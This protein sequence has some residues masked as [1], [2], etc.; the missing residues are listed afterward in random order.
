MAHIVVAGG[1]LGG[2]MAANLLARAG[3]EVTV[4]ERAS[5]AMDGRGAGIVTHAALVDG[6]R[7][8]GM[9]ADFELGVEVRGRV[10]LDAR[11]QV[12]GA[13][14]LR[15]VLTSWGRLYQLLQGLLPPGRVQYRQ[16][17]TAERVEQDARGVRL[18]TS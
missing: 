14:D 18:H 7:R 9:P 13:M 16:G 5:G 15:Q 2:L 10:T 11:G 12:L 1:S 6:L 4:L 17:V 3:A 8:C